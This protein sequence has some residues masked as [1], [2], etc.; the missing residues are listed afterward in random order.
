M[1]ATTEVAAFV[2]SGRELLMSLPAP[3]TPVPSLTDPFAWTARLVVLVGEC[4]RGVRPWRQVWPLLDVPVVAELWP[5]RRV[6]HDRSWRVVKVIGQQPA[7][8]CWELVVLVREELRYR[9]VAVRVEAAAH[10]G[11]GHW[12]PPGRR[13]TPVSRLHPD[14]QPEGWLATALHIL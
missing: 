6:R 12:G 11:I 13:L 2:M 3:V 7:S 8:G 10:G 14:Y 1:A 4:R 9:S 5:E